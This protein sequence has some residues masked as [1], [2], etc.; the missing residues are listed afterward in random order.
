MLHRCLAARCVL[1][2][3]LPVLLAVGAAPALV[4]HGQENPPNDRATQLVSLLDEDKA[5]FGGFV[6]FAG[7][8]NAPMDAMTH[9]R[10][11][12]IDLVMYDLV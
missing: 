6:N 8:G 9:S 5:V 2:I 1:G 11:S 10:D 7:V 3:A 4:M 12:N